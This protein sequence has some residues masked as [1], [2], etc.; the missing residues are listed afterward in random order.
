M[1]GG[2]QDGAKGSNEVDK[3]ACLN[4]GGNAARSVVV[5]WCAFGGSWMHPTVD[6]EFQPNAKEFL[7]FSAAFSSLKFAIVLKKT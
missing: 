7:T 2:A 5:V 4:I 6:P 3:R 1:L